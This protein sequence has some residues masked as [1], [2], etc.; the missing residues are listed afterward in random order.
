MDFGLTYLKLS[1]LRLSVPF[2]PRR[3]ICSKP[4]MTYQFESRILQKYFSY[5]G[6]P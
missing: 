2:V 4:T 3:F 5:P 1:A 6:V